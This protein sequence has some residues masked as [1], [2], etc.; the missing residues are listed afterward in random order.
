LEDVPDPSCPA[1]GA[2][3]KVEACSVCGTDVKMLEH[4]HKDLRYPRIRARDR[5]KDR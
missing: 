3:V 1:G 5:R 4:G 2:L